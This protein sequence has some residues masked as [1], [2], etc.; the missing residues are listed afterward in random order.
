VEVAFPD[1]L[2]F[3]VFDML[4]LDVLLLDGLLASPEAVEVKVVEFLKPVV[5]ILEML[6]CGI[7]GVYL[8]VMEVPFPDPV[9]SILLRVTLE[10]MSNT[11]LLDI[12][13][14]IPGIV[15]VEGFDFPPVCDAENV[16]V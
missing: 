12:T 6:K 11:V 5:V 14:P 9:D 13:V 16:K 2:V 4:L 3:L 10:G 15:I 7:P 1:W 8:L